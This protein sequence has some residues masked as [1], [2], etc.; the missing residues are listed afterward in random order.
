MIRLTVAL[1]LISQLTHCQPKEKKVTYYKYIPESSWKG[2]LDDISQYHN[3]TVLLT[4]FLRYNF[5]DVA[6][7]QTKNSE[8]GE[9]LWLSS[10][11][12]NLISKM[13]SLNLSEVKVLGTIDTTAHGHLNLYTG[14]FKPISISISR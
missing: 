5:E 14:E 2:I 10:V 6:L 8:K 3:D 7:Y 11:E 12:E 9:A 1:F 13:D 4:G